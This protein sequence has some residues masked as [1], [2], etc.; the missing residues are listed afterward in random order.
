MN[1]YKV[2]GRKFIDFYTIVAA[3]DSSEAYDKSEIGPVTWL[4]LNSDDPIEVID[5]ELIEDTSDEG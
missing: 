4:E 3:N 1:S 5:V 2:I